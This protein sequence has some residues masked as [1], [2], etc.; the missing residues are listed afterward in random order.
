MS[1]NPLIIDSYVLQIIIKKFIF[2]KILII[3][4]NNLNYITYVLDGIHRMT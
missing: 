1:Y 4:K 2:D 3:K